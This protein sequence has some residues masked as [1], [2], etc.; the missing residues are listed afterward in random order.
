MNYQET[1]EYLFSQVPMFQNLGAGAYKPGL[2]NTIA[3]A[4]SAGNP[5]ELFKSIH[6]AGTNG[7]GSTASTIAAVLQS[8][9]YK[10][11][12]YTSPHLVDFR[13]RI[14]VNGHK[15]P[16]D[17]VVEFVEN[18]RRNPALTKLCPTFFELTTIMAFKYFADSNV[19][20]AVIEA[21]LGGRL[22]CTN[23]IS[24]LLSIITNISLDHT[25]LLG[26]SEEAIAREKAGII[27]PG[28]PVV[29]GNAGG[30]VLDVFARA[31]SVASAPLY[32]ARNPLPYRS[33]LTTPAGIV[34]HGTPWGTV[35]GELS[36][37]CQTE[38]AATVMT[39]LQHL[40]SQFPAIDARAVREGFGNVCSLTGLA[41]RWMTLSASP[42]R[43]ICDTGHNAGGWQWLS[44]SLEKISAGLAAAGHTLHMVLGFVNDKNLDTIFPFMPKDA[45]Y[46]FA[47]PGVS[48]G[49]AAD[50]TAAAARQYGIEGASFASVGAAYGAAMEHA[51]E[52]DTIFV[53]GSTFVV[54]DL[55]TLLK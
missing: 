34:Y 23:I 38:N 17:Y 10:T 35:T 28:V 54:A 32:N 43:V 24:P 31:A 45:Q 50:S 29:I 46:Y 16:Q 6:I 30:A 5:H 14:R 48:R 53:G 55:L 33:A 22:D 47:T 8:A 26:H 51:G 20:V 2:G 13:E 19:D 42:V 18:F 4:D 9:G 41:G 52:N 40:S 7:K 37:A 39:A 36:G 12:L 25:A 15:I 44:S 1:T 3:L 21:G 27:K 11:G 49:R